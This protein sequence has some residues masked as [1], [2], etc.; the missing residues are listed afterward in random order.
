[1]AMKR[2]TPAEV[3]EAY[4]TTGLKPAKGAIEP[5]PGSRKCCAIGALAA[6]RGI[7]ATNG[8][9][10]TIYAPFDAE[11]GAEYIRGFWHGFD[12]MPGWIDRPDYRLGH[13]DGVATARL[14]FGDN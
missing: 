11:Y 2:I 14:V 1:M 7:K 8:D 13:E 9:T 10:S 12:A 6:A 3:Q 5:P 4:K